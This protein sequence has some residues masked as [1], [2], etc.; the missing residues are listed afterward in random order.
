MGLRIERVPTLSDNYTYVIACEDT[1][2]AAVIDA[3]EF[4]PVVKR[5]DQLGV[6]VVKVLS[7]HHHWD[8]SGANPDSSKRYGAPVFGHFS[9]ADRIPAYTDGLE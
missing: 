9:D 5:V 6:K 3:P 7:T 2:E 4:E 8:H 1:G